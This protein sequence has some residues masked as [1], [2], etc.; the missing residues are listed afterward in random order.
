MAVNRLLKLENKTLRILYHFLTWSLGNSCRRST[1][2]HLNRA[3]VRQG[4]KVFAKRNP[5][6]TALGDLNIR[7]TNCYHLGLIGPRINAA[8][9][10][11][12]AK[13]AVRL[14]ATND[15]DEASELASTLNNLNNERKKIEERCLAKPCSITVEI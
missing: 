8:G 9:R 6:L 14:L 11:S 15:P 5:G 12:D 1:S 2:H 13:L 4:L 10:L 3:I 7:E